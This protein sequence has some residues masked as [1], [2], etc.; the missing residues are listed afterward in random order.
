MIVRITNLTTPHYPS[1]EAGWPQGMTILAGRMVGDTFVPDSVIL[2]RLQITRLIWTWDFLDDS[3]AHANGE[4][5]HLQRSYGVRYGFSMNVPMECAGQKICLQVVYDTPETGRLTR[6]QPLD[7]VLPCDEKAQQIMQ[8][9]RV[10]EANFRGDHQRAVQI[11]DSLVAL[12]WRDFM[13]LVRATSS[14][15][16]VNRPADALRFLDLN[17]EANGRIETP[18]EGETVNDAFRQTQRQFYQQARQRLLEKVRN[19]EQQHK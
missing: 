16:A 8:G 17:F 13:G 12:E 5:S 10:L 18:T 4:M 1:L 3:A 2:G 9:S 19:Q 11:A 15:N 14:A 7:V 6:L